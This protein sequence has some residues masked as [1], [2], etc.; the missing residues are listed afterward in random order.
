MGLFQGKSLFS[1]KQKR[2]LVIVLFKMHQNKTNWHSTHNIPPNTLND[3]TALLEFQL[4]G[5]G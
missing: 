1:R 3:S 2:K 4:K 5:F